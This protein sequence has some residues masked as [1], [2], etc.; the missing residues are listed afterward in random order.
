MPFMNFF[1]NGG[2]EWVAGFLTAFV[3]LL[4]F[5]SIGLAGS[6]KGRT[7]VG[8]ER[9]EVED[10]TTGGSKGSSEEKDARVVSTEGAQPKKGRRGSYAAK[11]KRWEARRAFLKQKRERERWEKITKARRTRLTIAHY[12]QFVIKTLPMEESF[13]IP[14][15]SLVTDPASVANWSTKLSNHVA[16]K[17]GLSNLL[18]LETFYYDEKEGVVYPNYALQLNL[19]IPQ[20]DFR[21][22]K[23]IPAQE[24]KGYFAWVHPDF[25]D[26]SLVL[27]PNRGHLRLW[28]IKKGYLMGRV[29]LKFEDPALASPIHLY[30]RIR[31]HRMTKEEFAS[32]QGH[33]RSEMFAG[34]KKLDQIALHRDRL[35]PRYDYKSRRLRDPWVEGRS[36]DLWREVDE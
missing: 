1:L 20:E 34:V 3:F 25:P 33:I 8:K 35:K 17:D 19:E 7:K 16:F 32:R 27:T 28:R 11:K 30:G 6:E 21:K 23:R 29:N 4:I 31:A 5:S 14:G 15:V 22:G 12:D 10:L 26:K 9:L 13:Y 24:L 2:R 36:S 18:H